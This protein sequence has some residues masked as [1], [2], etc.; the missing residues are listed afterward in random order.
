MH[1]VMAVEKKVTLLSCKIVCLC[2]FMIQTSEATKGKCMQGAGFRTPKIP[3]FFLIT[4]LITITFF[5]YICASNFCAICYLFCVL[6]NDK[7]NVSIG[8]FS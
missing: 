3:N 1:I 8:T 4:F 2:A 6:S 5:P 7:L